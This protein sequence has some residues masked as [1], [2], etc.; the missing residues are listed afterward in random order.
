MPR[1]P[2][3]ALLVIA[4]GPGAAQAQPPEAGAANREALKRFEFLAGKWQG[5]ASVTSGPGMPVPVT[6][7]E[8]VRFKLNGTVL[9]IEGTGV[10]KLPGSD[11]EGVVFNAL[12]I[13]SY[14][15]PTKAYKLRAHRMEGAATDAAVKLHDTGRGFDWGFEVPGQK[16]E[17][18]YTMTLTD[19]GKWHEV[20]RMSR[21]GGKTWLPFIEMTLTRVKE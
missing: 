19:D 11:K 3:F 21:D 13:L 4:A 6:Q 20:G 5:K 7:T 8:E 17:I 1:L 15:A 2:L 10:G 16:I 9:L 18:K 14:D 12:A